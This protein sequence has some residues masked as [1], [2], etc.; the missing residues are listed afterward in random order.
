MNGFNINELIFRYRY[1][2]LILLLG[3]IL[4]GFGVF[5]S[6]SG[7]MSPSTK[8]E[9]LNSTTSGQVNAM[10]TVEISGQVITPG[11]Y[12]LPSGSRVED[13]L[14]ISGGLTADSDRIW[15]EKYLNRAAKL[16]DGQKVYIPAIGQQSG[17]MS[18]KTGGGDQTISSNF[19]SDSNPLININTAS[20]TQLDSLPGIGQVYGQ[21]IIEH[22]PYSNV[23]EL[24]SK[25][26]LK[27]S[28][29][30]KVK[31]LVSVY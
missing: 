28:V 6:K 4:T 22:R 3:L 15:T 19:S 21:S 9:V 13:L 31:D 16:T 14:I 11:V 2:L 18:A 29:Y 23:E 7:L 27:N 24:L 26:A 12:K 5:I 8:I 20:L 17:V 1:P 30:Q 10:I 25:G